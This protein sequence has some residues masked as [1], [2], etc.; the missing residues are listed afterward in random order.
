MVQSVQLIGYIGF[1]DHTV[2]IG[3]TIM[4]RLVAATSTLILLL[5]ASAASAVGLGNITLRSAL[6]EPLDAEIQITNPADLTADDLV[7]TLGSEV[8]FQ[9]AGVEKP[10][11]LQEMS[12]SVIE[13]DDDLVIAVTTEQAVE[14][15]FLDFLVELR[16]PS[17]RL[18]REY[19]LLLDPPTLLPEDSAM[20]QVFPAQDPFPG[21]VL[22]PPEPEPQPLPVEPVRRIEQL[23]DNQYRVANNDTLWEIALRARTNPSHTP[24]QIMLAIQDLNPDAFINQNINRVRAGRL[25]NLPSEEQIAVRS[26]AEA[27]REVERQNTALRGTPPA[28]EPQITATDETESAMP[29]GP[30]GRDPDGFLEVVTDA[31]EPEAATTAEGE[32]VGEIARLQ[33]ELA[34][35]RELNDE[36]RRQSEDQ[37]SRLSELEEQVELLSRLVALQSETASQLQAAAEAL[38]AQQA[39][40]AAAGPGDASLAAPELETPAAQPPSLLDQAL[41]WITQP[42][43]AALLLVAVLLLLLLMYRLRQRDLADEDTEEALEVDESLM[44]EDDAGD[45]SAM[46]D[47]LDEFEDLE[48]EP[49]EQGPATRGA[50]MAGGAAGAAEAIEN[51]ELYMAFQRYDEAETALKAAIEQNPNEP[52]L[53]LKLL[54]LYAETG[55]AGAFE[56]RAAEFQGDPAAVDSLRRQMHGTHSAAAT[57]TATAA[58]AQAD[59]FNE[60]E[61][62]SDLDD[63]DLEFTDSGDLE[64]QSRDEA[65]SSED[66]ALPLDFDLGAEDEAQGLDF[67]TDFTTQKSSADAVDEPRQEAETPDDESVLD[68]DMSELEEPEPAGGAD[69]DL[70]DEELISD[71]LTPEEDNWSMDLSD[72]AELS[73]DEMAFDFSDLES[74][75]QA[76]EELQDRTELESDDGVAESPAESAEILSD[77]GDTGAQQPLDDDWDD[78]FDFLDGADEV[79]TKLDLARAYI[80]MEDPEGARD[81]LNEVLEEG[82][83]SQQADARKL[84]ESIQAR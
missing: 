75:G 35:Q 56:S 6:T 36:M 54:E 4:T 71:L 68:F 57:A 10:L 65:D 37:Q 51:A 31:S 20:S 11:F 67:E 28:A 13:S 58:D 79:S 32:S 5:A 62:A 60:D 19:T 61:L 44:A 24:Q 9:R 83:E 76:T 33:N 30:V 21:E 78:D 45:D 2:F 52:S 40:Q 84:L 70:A 72:E 73:D 3:K 26:A 43:N 47:E 27:V 14:E 50:A 42:Y 64:P 39:D 23:P 46:A 7:V 12:F 18:I 55:N 74:E 38:Q 53:A 16:W 1:Q 82:D 48:A 49:A 81:I 69:A 59:D 22:T 66:D 15:P 77:E 29:A 34:I 63:L 25:L 8:D 80:D 17:G 41:R